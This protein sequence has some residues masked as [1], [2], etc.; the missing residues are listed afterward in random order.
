MRIAAN[1][2]DARRRRTPGNPAREF[3]RISSA[4]RTGAPPR[5]ESTFPVACQGIPDGHDPAM[6]LGLILVN[7]P[8]IKQDSRRPLQKYHPIAA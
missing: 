8:G 1:E 7:S 5:A 3:P 4:P 6:K 2:L